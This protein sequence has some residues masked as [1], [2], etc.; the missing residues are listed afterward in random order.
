MST[1]ADVRDLLGKQLYALA[2]LSDLDPANEKDRAEIQHAIE[3]A[4]A[5]AIVAG[6]YTQLVRAEIDAARTMAE[7]NVTT[8]SVETTDLRRIGGGQK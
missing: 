4:K 2:G 6:Q 8:A 3:V 7:F 5:S 1:T